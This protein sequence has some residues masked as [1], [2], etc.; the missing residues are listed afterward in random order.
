MGSG[1][2]P[3][4]LQEVILQGQQGG[5]ADGHLNGAPTS[6]RTKCAY[7]A[8][9]TMCV[10]KRKLQVTL[11]ECQRVTGRWE[12][13]TSGKGVTKSHRNPR[14]V[15]EGPFWSLRRRFPGGEALEDRDIGILWAHPPGG[16]EELLQGHLS[17]KS[18]LEGCFSLRDL[19]GRWEVGVGGCDVT[20]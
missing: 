9:S 20:F 12:K 18:V 6:S 14:E 11:T 7:T 16:D 1:Q 4:T 17:L 2:S 5:R 13:G 8:F 10:A 15:W 19:A 3:S